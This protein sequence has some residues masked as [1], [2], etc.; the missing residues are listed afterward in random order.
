MGFFNNLV[1]HADKINEGFSKILEN[2]KDINAVINFLGI[3]G[4]QSLS[5]I[6]GPEVGKEGRE[7]ALKDY[8]DSNEEV[9]SVEDLSRPEIL[10]I[11]M[12]SNRN[13]LE[14]LKSSAAFGYA[15]PNNVLYVSFT[16]CPFLQAGLKQ[17]FCNYSKGYLKENFGAIEVELVNSI[18]KGSNCCLLKLTFDYNIYEYD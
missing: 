3:S 17:G 14:K 2:Q 7:R 1:K 5:I 9:N 18:D 6:I 13:L 16:K 11:L 10:N 4:A 12:D 15:K 8:I